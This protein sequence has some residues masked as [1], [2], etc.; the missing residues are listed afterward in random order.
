MVG[1]S[2]ELSWV[3]LLS[4]LQIWIKEGWREQCMVPRCSVHGLFSLCGLYQQNVWAKDMSPFNWQVTFQEGCIR[5][6]PTWIPFADDAQVIY[7]F[8]PAN[9]CNLEEGALITM[10]DG[11]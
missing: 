2:R 7:Q 6:Q 3:W 9:V 5:N 8:I 10:V 11:F 1:M 4:H